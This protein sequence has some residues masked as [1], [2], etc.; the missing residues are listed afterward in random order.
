MQIHLAIGGKQEGPY[1]VDHIN[2]SI[3][4]GAIAP[5]TTLAWYEG[6]AQWIPLS[7]VPGVTQGA[8]IAPGAPHAGG[9]GA[10]PPPPPL[11]GTDAT[12]GIIPYKNPHALTGYYLGIFSVIPFIGFIL[13]IPALILGVVGLKKR[14]RNPQIRGG[15]HAWVAICVGGFSL[16]YHLAI[17]LMMVIQANSR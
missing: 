8:A 11:T 3:R 15:A 6:C 2:N 9:S 7:L 17:V 14:T 1:T 16:A 13:S 10:V 5:A 12:A 4:S